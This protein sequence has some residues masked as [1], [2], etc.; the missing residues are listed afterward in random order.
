MKKENKIYVGKFIPLK[1]KTQLFPDDNK[2]VIELNY[3]PSETEW[4]EWVKIIKKVA[5]DQYAQ[6][7][8]DT[9]PKG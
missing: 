1:E 5:G 2:I 3:K 4:K 8:T 7:F 6:R 9:T